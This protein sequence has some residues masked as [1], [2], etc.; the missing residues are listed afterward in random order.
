MNAKTTT[1]TL[2]ANGVTR[3]FEFSHAERLLQ[4]PRNGGWEL[5]ENSNYEFLDNG[6]RRR[7]NKKKDNGKKKG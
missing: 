2:V 6:L 1:V 4:M 3:E 5:P 7:G